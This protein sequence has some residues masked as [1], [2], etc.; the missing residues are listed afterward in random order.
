MA[1][2]EALKNH[3]D[4]LRNSIP[5]LKGVLLASVEDAVAHALSNGMD[6]YRVA[7]WRGALRV[8]T[9]D[10]LTRSWQ[11]GWKALGEREHGFLG[12]AVYTTASSSP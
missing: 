9:D 2:H 1:K 5:E 8:G 12:P 4:N 11:R 7:R 3:L 10:Q 6:A